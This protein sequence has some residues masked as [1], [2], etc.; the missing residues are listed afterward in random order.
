[1]T[2]ATRI[3]LSQ[4]LALPGRKTASGGLNPWT[5]R[6]VGQTSLQ[7]T[8]APGKNRPSYDPWRRVPH[9]QQR[10]T[11]KTQPE[12]K[13]NCVPNNF[14]TETCRA[15]DDYTSHEDVCQLGNTLSDPLSGNPDRNGALEGVALTAGGFSKKFAPVAII[16]GFLQAYGYVIKYTSHCK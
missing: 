6:R 12:K 8:D 5:R 7:P 15:A 9:V 14:G 4:P 13:Y 16:G 3:S 1:M 2:R 11:Q 10:G